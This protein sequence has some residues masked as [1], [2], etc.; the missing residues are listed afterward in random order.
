MA[1][2]RIFVSSTFYDLRHIRDRLREFIEELGYEAVLSEVGNIPY[3]PDKAPDDSCY[4]EVERCHIMVLIIGG[5]YG[6]P[7]TGEVKLDEKSDAKE[8]MYDSYRSITATEYDRAIRRGTPVYT[9]V[10]AAVLHDYE[11]FKR[12]RD[13]K[14]VLYASVENVNIF[15]LLDD[16]NI[17]TKNKALESFTDFGD[18]SSWLRQQWAGLFALYLAKKQDNV[19]IEDLIQR[20]EKLDNVAGAI[21]E[22]SA[23]IIENVATKKPSDANEIKQKVETALLEKIAKRFGQSE[24]VQKLARPSNKSAV[25]VLNTLRS[26]QSASAFFEQLGF[27]SRTET[28]GRKTFDFKSKDD[29]N[30]YQY[31]SDPEKTFQNLRHEFLLDI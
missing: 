3:D 28:D 13:R 27:A 22:Y 17:R 11:T 9:L 19:K 30:D 1:T 6:S 2:P 31:F 10:D 20:I 15:R 4:E 24:Y 21:K 12:N 23:K 8:K 29:S 14:D 16:I 5:R 7:A 25:D 18:I 26:A